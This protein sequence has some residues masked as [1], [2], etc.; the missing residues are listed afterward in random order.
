[1]GTWAPQHAILFRY[2]FGRRI[3]ARGRN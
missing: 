3:S 1:L 2:W